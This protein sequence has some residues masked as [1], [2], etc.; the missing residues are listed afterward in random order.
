M[1]THGAGAAAPIW[2]CHFPT[3]LACATQRD[4]GLWKEPRI[5]EIWIPDPVLPL[6]LQGV[7]LGAVRRLGR[8]LPGLPEPEAKG[9]VSKLGPFCL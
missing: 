2:R 8:V 1:Q 7:L 3:C 5:R 9:E 6:C 4:A